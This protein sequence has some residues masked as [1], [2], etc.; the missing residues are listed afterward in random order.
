M[1]IRDSNCLTCCLM[2]ESAKAYGGNNK[3]FIWKVMSPQFSIAISDKNGNRTISNFSKGYL[4][5]NLFSTNGNVSTTVSNPNA[6]LE[7]P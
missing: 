5:P 2:E 6:A 1:C 4:Q 3:W 7:M